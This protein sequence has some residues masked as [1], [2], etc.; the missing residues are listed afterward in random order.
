M[1]DPGRENATQP[2]LLSYCGLPEPQNR[3]RF[4]TENGE[5]VTNIPCNLPSVQVMRGRH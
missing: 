4:G 5:S 2:A 3:D 1:R